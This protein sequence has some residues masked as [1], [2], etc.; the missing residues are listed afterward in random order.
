MVIVE[1]CGYEKMAKEFP[2]NTVYSD[3]YTFKDEAS[4]EKYRASLKAHPE[5]KVPLFLGEMKAGQDNAKAARWMAEAMNKEGWH[6]AV[7]T[8]KGVNVGGWAAFN[9]H[10]TMR[11]D[12]SKDSYG[13]LLDKWTTGLSQW[14]DPAK[15]KN[16]Y[17]NQWWIDG[18][19]QS[20]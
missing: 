19:R 14:Q 4:L 11:Y 8:Y 12:L 16:Y 5:V 10:G 17:V 1:W 9:Y 2:K 18:F 7:W 15:P 6:W 20:R 3:H 13:S